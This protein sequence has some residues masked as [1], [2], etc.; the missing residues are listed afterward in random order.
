MAISDY[1][2]QILSSPVYVFDGI[3]NK[4]IGKN[5]YFVEIELRRHPF[6]MDVTLL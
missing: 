4:L 1:V 5:F 3:I 6:E 2:E